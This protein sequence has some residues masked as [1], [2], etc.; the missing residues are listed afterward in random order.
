MTRAEED[1][2]RELLIRLDERMA[3]LSDDMDQVKHV[4]LEGNGSPPLTMQVATNKMKIDRLE[5][6]RVDKKLPRAAW[7]GILISTILSVA[8]LVAAFQ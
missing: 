3:K 7:L 4:L 2:M 5:E 6:E 1:D 8:G